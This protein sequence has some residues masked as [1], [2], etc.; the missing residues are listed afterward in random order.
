MSLKDDFYPNL[1]KDD[2]SEEEFDSRL[3]EEPLILERISYWRLL[4]AIFL[5]VLLASGGYIAYDYYY[6][7][8]DCQDSYLGGIFD[9]STYVLQTGLIPVF[10]NQSGNVTIQYLNLTQEVNKNG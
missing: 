1:K 10:V 2:Y 8:S 9:T 6:P 4:L 7:S 3:S 5:G